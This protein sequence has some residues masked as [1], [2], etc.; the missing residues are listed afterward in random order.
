MGFELKPSNGTITEGGKAC[1]TGGTGTVLCGRPIQRNTGTR[2]AE[3][4]QTS[5]NEYVGFGMAPA[6]VDL[7]RMLGSQKMKGGAGLYT[8]GYFVSDGQD[9]GYVRSFGRQ[10]KVNLAVDTNVAGPL[11]CVWS[12]GGSEHLRHPIE[13]G[14]RFGVGSYD[15][16]SFEIVHNT[17]TTDVRRAHHPSLSPADNVHL[18]CILPF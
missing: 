4:K 5:D 16:A 3:F 11:E 10:K 8:A 18:A 13:E 6:T 2:E 17:V 1:S 15:E 7:E 14:W 9:Q 12:V